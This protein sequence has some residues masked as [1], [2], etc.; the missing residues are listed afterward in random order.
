MNE[1]VVSILLQQ[2]DEEF[3]VSSQ[4]VSIEERLST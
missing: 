4:Q 3:R 1:C 2:T